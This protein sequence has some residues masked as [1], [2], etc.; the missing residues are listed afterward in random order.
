MIEKLNITAED[1]AEVRYELARNVGMGIG[2]TLQ[3]MSFMLG[4][5][6]AFSPV[7][8]TRFIWKKVQ[9]AR[10]KTRFEKAVK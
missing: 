7:I 5:L 9:W 3:G 6:I 10:I 8:F 1:V 4:I 2:F